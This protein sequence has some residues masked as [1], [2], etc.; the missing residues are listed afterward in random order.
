MAGRIRALD[1]GATPL[2]LVAGWPAALRATLRIILANGFPHILWWGPQY[3]QFYN[4]AYIPVLG[5]K[6]PDKALGLPGSQCWP[7]I[8]HVIGPLIERPFHGGPPAWDEDILLE[9]E[10]HG[11]TEESHF[12]IAYSPVPDETA[13][14][15]IGGVLGTIH[16]ITGKI[17]GERRTETLRDLAARLGEARTEQEACVAAAE[18]LAEKDKDIPFLL[19]YLINHDLRQMELVASAGVTPGAAISARIIHLEQP[20]D[21]PIQEALRLEKMQVVG[22]L[23]D[24]CQNHPSG[25]AFGLADPGGFEARENAS[26][27]PLNR[28]I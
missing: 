13:P 21:W 1:W 2:G 14:D 18:L 10:R 16:E 7:E 28:A 15:G 22:R 26:G 27:R 24:Q 3:I 20:S 8:W 17:I 25:A 11:F 19:L 5:A 4:D 9:V 23:T 6:H 12:T